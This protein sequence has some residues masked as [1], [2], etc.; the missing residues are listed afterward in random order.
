MTEREMAGRTE[1]GE[2]AGGAVT[3]M[4]SERETVRVRERE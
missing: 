3:S 4:E 2:V 1:V